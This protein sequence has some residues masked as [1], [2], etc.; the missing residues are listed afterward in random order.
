MPK[1]PDLKSLISPCGPVIDAAAAERTREALAD[2]ADAAG[3]R[4]CLDEAW[5]ALQPVFAASPYLARLAR[6]SPERLRSLLDAAPDA[7]LEELLA[8]TEAMV[9][10]PPELD[11]AKVRLRRLKGD[12]HL[13]C[14]LADLGGVWDLGKVTGALT[15]FADLSVHAA[16]A[17]AAAVERARGRLQGDPSSAEGPVPGLFGLAMG[18]YGAFELNYSSDIDLTLFY[19]PEALPLAEGVEPQGFVNRIAQSLTNILN[20]RTSDGYVFRLDL[21]LRPDPASTPPVIAAAAALHYYETVGQNWERAAFIKARPGAGDLERGVEFLKALEPFVW[22]RS[23]DYAAIADVHSIKRQIHVHRA[24]ERL[25]AAG[26]NLKLGGGGIREVEFFVQTQQ[27]ILGG[28]D[29]SLRSPRT[30]EALEALT[31]AGHVTAAAAKDMASAYQRLRGWE[32]RVQMLE[33]EQTH[34]LPASGEDRL[35]VAALAGAESLEAFDEQVSTTLKTVNR[36]YGELFA[37]DESLSSEHGSLVFTGVDDDPA[38][39]ETLGRMGFDDPARVSST[40]RAWHHGRIPATRSERGRELFTRLAPRLLEAAA[41]T[42]APDAAFTR[43]AAFFSGLSAG[44]QIQSLFLAQP[45]LFELIVQVMAFSPKLAS[46]LA[47]RPAALDAL[48]DQSFFA[49]LDLDSGVIAELAAAAASAGGFEQAMDAVRRIHREQAF[50]IGVQAISG[51]AKSDEIGRAYSD[52]ADA[53]LHALAPAALRETVRQGGDFPGQVA[54]VALGKLGSREM[55]ATSD[56]DLMTVYA[57]P[58][59]AAASSLKGWAAETFYGRFTQRLIAALSAPTAEGELYEIDMQLRPSGAKG[60]VAVSLGGFERYYAEEAD[61][62][63]FLVLTRARVAWASS[64]DFGQRV[65]AAIEAALRRPRDFADTAHDVR[66]MRAVIERERPPHGVWDFKLSPGGQTDCE[67]AAQFLQIAH[68]G[69][70]GPLRPGTLDALAALTSAGLAAQSDLDKLARSWRLHQDLA[71]LK[72]AALGPRADPTG[73][74]EPFRLRLAQAGGAETLPDLERKLAAVRRS[75]R[76]AFE[77][78]VPAGDGMAEP[79]RL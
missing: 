56:L 64:E 59:P 14:A 48:L 44:V 24:D 34:V 26:A 29:R 17:V 35:R 75:A 7:R 65:A 51:A 68:A 57:A 47:R 25:E 4:D 13:L 50:R 55:T 74:P 73:E 6:T 22:R 19:E 69:A 23:L 31:T 76:A 79:E 66:A 43:F 5:P 70:G 58:D 36:R 54:V 71:Q 33:D 1:G 77:A 20:D 42:G 38:T 72:R 60:P 28:R 18:K 46:T 37:S 45:G 61:T 67:F 53:C 15:G 63:E 2:A 9:A 12:L 30:L 27:L 32:H 21:R 10:A 41:R 62:W 40:I 49:N 78:V 8:A 3:W 52:L 39:L 11:E 16:L